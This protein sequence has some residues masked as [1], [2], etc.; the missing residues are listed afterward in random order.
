MAKQST[1]YLTAFNSQVL[2]LASELQEMY[3]DDNNIQ[4]SH[5]AVTLMKKINPRLVH[6]VVMGNINDYREQIFAED[7]TFFKDRIDEIEEAGHINSSSDAND[8]DQANDIK[9]EQTAAEA[10][11]AA[12]LKKEEDKKTFDFVMQVKTY[13]GKMPPKS[14]KNI[15]TYLKVLFKLSDRLKQIRLRNKS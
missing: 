9:D 2:N 11:K 7:E 1:T 3:P 10:A 13:W 4:T 12:A 6:D 14:K 8:V 5:T 15:W